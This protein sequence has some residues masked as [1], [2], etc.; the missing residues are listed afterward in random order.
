M[1]KVA[2]LML[3]AVWFFSTT[4][5][6][7]ACGGDDASPKSKKPLF[8]GRDVKV[9]GNKDDQVSITI[10]I[11]D[12][13]LEQTVNHLYNG[14]PPVGT[15]TVF[16]YGGLVNQSCWWSAAPC[17]VD[18][19]TSVVGG[20]LMA[21]FVGVP[22]GVVETIAALINDQFYVYGLSANVAGNVGTT[23]QLTNYCGFVNAATVSNPEQNFGVELAPFVLDRPDTGNLVVTVFPG[24]D[25]GNCQRPVYRLV[26]EVM[27]TVGY[28]VTTA[29]NV[30]LTTSLMYRPSIANPPT[31]T[32]IL[33]NAG[34]NG[35]YFV[36]DAVV[37]GFFPFYVEADIPSPPP[38]TTTTQVA[39]TVILHKQAL[40]LVAGPVAGGTD[41]CSQQLHHIV[42]LIQPG[43]GI[44]YAYQVSG[45]TVGGGSCFDVKS[46]NDT[47]IL[48]PPTP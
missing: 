31:V 44:N 37:G 9:T 26:I 40:P 5:I 10:P 6:M 25:N 13:A 28:P 2:K 20:N 8:V 48:G 38:I 23:V 17:L 30:S 19:S 41:I 14:A 18:Y 12:N 27:N 35:K 16:L 3:L 21:T 24:A 15:A 32:P 22:V 46:V 36:I 43:A 29:V 45:S 47:G 33:M 39:R 34:A 4:V 42:D 11:G 7:Y 1:K